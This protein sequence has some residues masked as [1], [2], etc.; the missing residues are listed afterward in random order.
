MAQNGRST[1]DGAPFKTT[2]GGTVND[3]AGP[4]GTSARMEPMAQ[5]R[6]NNR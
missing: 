4:D 5:T 1:L 3:E 6:G 2:I